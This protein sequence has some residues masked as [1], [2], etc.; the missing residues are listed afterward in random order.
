MDFPSFLELLTSRLLG[1]RF[2]V[3]ARRY[4]PMAA[5]ALALA[6]TAGTLVAVW[7]LEDPNR[8]PNVRDQTFLVVSAA[9]GALAM[10][11]ALLQYLQTGRSDGSRAR[12]S[13][14]DVHYLAREL[15]T[16]RNEIKA[17]RARLVNEDERAELIESLR[18]GVKSEA[19]Q[20]M[21][22]EIKSQIE[23]ESSSSQAHAV[24]ER[25]ISR[26]Q[27]EVAALSRR[28]NLN[29][30]IGIITTM[31]GLG[32][33]GQV[34]FSAA[35]LP[36]DPAVVLSFYLPRISLV[37]F[38]E[39]FSYFFLNLYK[40]S[41]A[42]IKYFQNE[43]TNMEA[44]F[45]CLQI[46]MQE[47]EAGL[48]PIVVETLARTERNFILSKDQTTVALARSKQESETSIGLLQVVEKILSRSEK[49]GD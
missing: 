24:F 46:A 9:A 15:A 26:L 28:G 40:W 18:V 35:Y 22:A 10:V 41:L 39:L 19:G 14:T 4:F 36:H 20:A 6:A 33:L 25:G 34:V 47:R 12:N 38:V 44:R 23:A 27:A 48:L 17:Q 3:L 21:L 5:L 31:A 29:L 1:R 30:V 37:V 7:L 16:L 13:G 11:F 45:T 32:I 43:I 42:E 8:N 49:K 2:A